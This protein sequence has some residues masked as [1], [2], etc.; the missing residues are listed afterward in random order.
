MCVASLLVCLRNRKLNLSLPLNDA[1]MVKIVQVKT[2]TGSS[3]TTL[4]KCPHSLVITELK[5]NRRIK[6][7]GLY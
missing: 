4:I 6:L 1:L 5:K 2:L 3:T 7:E